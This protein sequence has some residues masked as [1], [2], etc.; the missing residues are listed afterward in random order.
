MACRWALGALYLLAF[1]LSGLASNVSAALYN[2]A[3][4]PLALAGLFIALYVGYDLVSLP[5]GLYGGYVL[6]HRFGLSVQS[7]P[8]WL[9]DSTKG[10]AL[11][12]GFGLVLVEAL[13]WLM[14]ALPDWWWLAAS[15]G[16]VVVSIVLANL[17][18]VLLVPI[19]Y[20]LRP[21][22]DQDQAEALRRLAERAGT[23]V[24]GVYAIELSRKTRAA[25]AALMGLGNTRR[26]VLGDTL[27]RG[28]EKREIEVVFAH[29]LGHYVHGDVWR[30]LGLQ[31]LSVAASLYLSQL[32][33]LKGA[34]SFGFRGA[35][36]IA[37]LPLLALAVG[38]LSLLGM[39]LLNA[40]SRFL[41]ESADE[42]ALETTDDPTAFRSAMERL[43][44]LNLAEREPDRWVTL[45]LY[46][47]P[48]IGDRMRHAGEYAGRRRARP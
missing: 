31:S 20:H 44:D 32:V 23:R 46:D 39:P 1:L 24:Q 4:Y 15:G 22:E 13:Y 42:Y 18:P 45:L 9:A 40:A 21:L 12:A 6:P 11:G 30:L 10:T 27:L 47:H 38:L 28:F 48:P 16:T 34:A 2:A 36:D 29:E 8:A 43:A 26:I 25:N 19:F 14:A 5:L 41:E 35:T 37:T 17:A 7:L 3:P 33:L